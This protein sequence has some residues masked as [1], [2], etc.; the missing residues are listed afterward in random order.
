MQTT[1]ALDTLIGDLKTACQGTGALADIKS[2]LASFVEA[3]KTAEK[4]VP[5]Y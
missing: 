4:D 2:I 5:E 1:K 3:P